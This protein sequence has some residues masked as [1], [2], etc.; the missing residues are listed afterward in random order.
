[1]R[2]LI[3]FSY[4]GS[5]FCGFQRQ[6]DKRSVQ[7][8]IEDALSKIYL[9]D[10]LIKG[11]GRTDS[12]VHAIGQTASFDVPYI[13]K[14]LKRILN[15]NLMD[16]KI[17]K[18]KKVSDDFHARFNAKG[19]V[20]FYKIKLNSR[21]K[22]PYY[23]SVKN[24][25][26]KSMV[27]VSKLFLGTHNFKNF[28]AGER[29]NYQTYIKSIKFYYVFGFLYIKFT[30]AGFYRYMVRNLVG[31][32]LDVGRGKKTVFEVKSMLDNPFL[33]KQLSTALP[34]GLYLLK[35]LY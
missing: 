21:E 14:G 22:S 11:A 29:V 3:I 28:V 9:C 23:L 2:L 31:A 32:M 13:Y 35:V 26:L 1:M 24:V 6:K 33:E 12:K 30:G 15:K 8:D 20:Y 19:K 25:N 16:I 4:D 34:S 7:K 5:K 10:I 27:K 18:I 17:R